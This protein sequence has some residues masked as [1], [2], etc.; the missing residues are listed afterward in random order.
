M[1]GAV[2]GAVSFLVLALLAWGAIATV[3]PPA[4][5]PADAPAA[6]FSADRARVH[7]ERISATPHPTGSAAASDVRRYILD[8]LGAAG[9]ATRV[10]DAVGSTDVLGGV[11][12]ARVQNVIATLPGSGSSG[13]LFLV[14]HYDSATISHGAGDDGAG[15]A[16]LLETARALRAGAA[17]RNDVV[18]VFTDAEEA[19]LCGAEAFVN[20]DPAAARGGVVLNFESRGS[21]GPAIMFETSRGNADL[22][23]AYAKAAPRPVATSF[24]AAVYRL[25]P[26]DTDF[27]PFRDDDRFAGLNTAYIDGSAAYHQPQDDIAHQSAE[28]L[29]HMGDGGLAMARALGVAD[30]AAL[31]Q[32]AGGDATYFPVLGRLVRYPGGFVWPI[33][34]LALLAVGAAAVVVV[35]G[36]VLTAPRLA[37]C[38]AWGLAPLLGVVAATFVLWRGLLLAQP[39]YGQFADPWVPG[40]YRVAV[41][42]LV[43]TTV[44]AWLAPLR[45]R[46]GTAA[47]T[48][49]ALAWVALLGV[50]AAALIPGGSYLL[51]L[52]ALLGALA[53]IAGVRTRWGLPVQLA[54]AAVTVLILA[55]TAAIFFPATGVRLAAP[56][57]VFVAIIAIV[58]LPLLDTLL[59]GPSTGSRRLVRAAPALATALVAALAIGGGLAANRPSAVHPVPV[60]LRYLL[61][62]DTGKAYWARPG[63]DPTGWTGP[64]VQ[65]RED[66]SAA[67]PMLK[68]RSTGTTTVGDAPV[69]ALA[70]ADVRVVSERVENGNRLLQLHVTSGR[71][72]RVLQLTQEE[73]V[74]LAASARGRAVPVDD[75]FTLRFHGLPAEGL[76]VALTVEGTSRLRIRVEDA[77]DGID[78][79]PGFVPRPEGVSALGGHTAEMAIVARTVTL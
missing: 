5:G 21:S 15:V 4:P 28:S 69:A 59:P 79:L 39:G 25:L 20:Q 17:L 49:G 51:A 12:L 26:N 2:T 65:R 72:A 8:Q 7:Q 57:A 33:A 19:C 50:V 27:S 22:V 76:D 42:A 24:A 58:L 30:I 63:A 75:G 64:L 35:R 60:A 62:A 78:A 73:G 61:D 48:V 14:A 37:A 38:I 11:A 66:L 46:F 44:L 16:T 53:V 68:G 10:Q 70:P 52:P 56:S 45:R 40:W 67:F 55:P 31:T 74:V 41:V 18:L 29:Q 36:G 9:I 77:S 23:A 6:V 13:T 71:G 1:R 3:T 32:P 43:F 54:A 47:L 34:I